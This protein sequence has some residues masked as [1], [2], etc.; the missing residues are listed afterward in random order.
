M[1]FLIFKEHIRQSREQQL[2]ELDKHDPAVKKHP[3]VGRSRSN[4]SQSS[5][6]FEAANAINTPCYVPGGDLLPILLRSE[7]SMTPND[8]NYS[9]NMYTMDNE[10]HPEMCDTACQTRESLFTTQAYSSNHSQ[11]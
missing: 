3:D 10:P 4:S 6:R 7:R 11:R 5:H 9:Q 1:F 8:D 2:N